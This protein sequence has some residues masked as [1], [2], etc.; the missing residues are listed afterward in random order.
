MNLTLVRANGKKTNDETVRSQVDYIVKRGLTGARGKGW[1]LTQ[2]NNLPPRQENDLWVFTYNLTFEKT[3]GQKGIIDK[4][5]EEIKK[6]ICETGAGTK[7][8]PY[9]W[10]VTETDL[11][12]PIPPKPE[13]STPPISDSI[14]VEE[15]TPAE[16]IEDTPKTIDKL[17]KPAKKPITMRKLRRLLARSRPQE[18][19]EAMMGSMSWDKLMLTFANVC[20]SKSGQTQKK[21][22]K[23]IWI[24]RSRIFHRTMDESILAKVKG[25]I[26]K[27]RRRDIYECKCKRRFHID[28]A[29][30]KNISWDLD[31]CEFVVT[32]PGCKRKEDLKAGLIAFKKLES[33]G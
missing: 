17:A 7:F 9:P 10:K 24:N 1:E 20:V 28:P 15:D 11:P 29:N 2:V 8:G 12:A 21:P 26:F 6:V 4:Q 31:Q 13:I 5:W 23:K 14:S 32:C 3:S 27:I 22:H 33:Q 25:N 16:D 18:F 19:V 30:D